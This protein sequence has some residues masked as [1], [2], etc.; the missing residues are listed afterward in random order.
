MKIMLDTRDRVMVFTA[1]FNNISVKSSLSVLLV[2]ETGVPGETTDLLQVIDKLYHIILHRVNLAM[3][4]IRTHTLTPVYV[5][6]YK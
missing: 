3:N 4:G 1:T 5:Y 6:K 2:K